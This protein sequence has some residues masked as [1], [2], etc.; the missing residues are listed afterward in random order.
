MFPLKFETLNLGKQKL[1]Q[2]YRQA[3]LRKNLQL[4]ARIIWAIR[5]FFVN[6]DYLEV[7]TPIRIPAPAPE[8]HI[9]AVESGNWFLQTSPELCMK[10]MLSAGFIGY[11]KFANASVKK[12]EAGFIFPK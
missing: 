4:R 2:Q 5:N 11:F 1:M 7:E 12:K 9:D 10:R 3:S 6:H 8:A